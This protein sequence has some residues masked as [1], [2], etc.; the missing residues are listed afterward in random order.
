MTIRASEI[1]EVREAPPTELWKPTLALKFGNRLWGGCVV[2]SKRRGLMRR[3]VLTPD[4]PHEFA[5]CVGR[6]GQRR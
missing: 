1:R 4:N 6:I 3:I 2:I 5:E